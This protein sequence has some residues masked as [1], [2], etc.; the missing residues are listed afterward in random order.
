MSTGFSICEYMYPFSNHFG[1]IDSFKGT[2][3]PSKISARGKLLEIEHT[4]CLNNTCYLTF[5]HFHAL[6]CQVS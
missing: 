5:A 3:V 2:F 6:S 1:G 4:P